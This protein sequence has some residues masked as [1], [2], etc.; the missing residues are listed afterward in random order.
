MI[1]ESITQLRGRLVRERERVFVEVEIEVLMLKDNSCCRA[2]FAKEERVLVQ[3]RFS[4]EGC[5][6]GVF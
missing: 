2:E 4:F 1:D 3:R 5:Y 6:E